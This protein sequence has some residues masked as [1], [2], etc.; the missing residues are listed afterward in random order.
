MKKNTLLFL[1]STFHNFL[2]GNTLLFN[3]L[4]DA[5]KIYHLIVSLF[6]IAVYYSSFKMAEEKKLSTK[7]NIVLSFGA[8][9]LSMPIAYIFVAVVLKLPSDNN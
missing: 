4:V 9:L 2:V 8:S 5:P 3:I 1:I 6:V 7:R